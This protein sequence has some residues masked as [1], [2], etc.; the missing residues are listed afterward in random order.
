MLGQIVY[1]SGSRKIRPEQE[2]IHGLPVLQVRIDPDGHWAGH[3]LEKAGKMLRRAGVRR[4][5]TPV[6]FQGWDVLERRGLCRVESAGFLRANG[7]QLIL[8]ALR[9]RGWDPHRCAVALRDVRAG[10]DMAAT[11]EELCPMV[12]NLCI[13][14]PRGG[15]KLKEY[16]RREYG[17]AL[18]PDHCGVEGAVCLAPGTRQEGEVVLRLYGEDPELCGV[19]LS[20]PGVKTGDTQV[21]E[22]F[23]ALWE[24]GKVRKGDLEFA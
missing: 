18:C 13:S 9:R 2:Q 7:G 19:E 24:A 4:V 6:G 20:L 16:L 5:L 10:R 15:Q 3:R 14:A 21:I 11:A 8:A 12:R 23:A 1:S 17:V 22:L